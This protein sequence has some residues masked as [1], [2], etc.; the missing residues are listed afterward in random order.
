VNWVQLVFAVALLLVGGVLIAYNAM[1][2]WLTVVRKEEAPK[3]APIVGGVIAAAGIVA[4]PVD[5]SWTWAWVP[6]LIDWGGLRIFVSH[7]MSR[8][9]KS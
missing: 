3:V 7:W 9:A 6:L 2:F 8:R 1:I 5:G 4:L